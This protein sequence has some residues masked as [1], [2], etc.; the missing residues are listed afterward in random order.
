[1]PVVHK[2]AIKRARQSIKRHKRNKAILHGTKTATKK[3]K[4]AVSEKNT[5]LA[6][7]LLRDATSAIAKAATKGTLH[8]KTASRKISRLT[9]SVNA[10][11]SKS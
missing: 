11:T 10:A 3:V 9:R 2:S 1:M 8:K 6:Q 4:A 5:E 7:T